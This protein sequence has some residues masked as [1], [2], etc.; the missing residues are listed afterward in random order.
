MIPSKLFAVET[1]ERT[2]IEKCVCGIIYKV[3]S[4]MNK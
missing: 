4:I 3:K 2:R 1:P